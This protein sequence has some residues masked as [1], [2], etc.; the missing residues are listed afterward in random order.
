[1]NVGR[2]RR[3]SVFNTVGS[4]EMAKPEDPGSWGGDFLL[5]I[6]PHLHLGGLRNVVS[7]PSGVQGEAPATLRFRTFYRLTKSLLV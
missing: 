2:C 6:S 4:T 1:M 7:S 5:P 3:Q